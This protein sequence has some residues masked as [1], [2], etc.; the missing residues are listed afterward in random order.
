MEVTVG[1]DITLVLQSGLVIRAGAPAFAA[2]RLAQVPD[3]IAALQARGVT[4]IALDLRYAGS[5]AVKLA[6]AGDVR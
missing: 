4:P 3:I 6:P 1:P 5:V 2:E